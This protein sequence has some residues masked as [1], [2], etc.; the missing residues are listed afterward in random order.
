MAA[1]QSETRSVA[2]DASNPQTHS[3]YATLHAVDRALRPIYSK[4]GLAL[5]FDTAKADEE[6]HI[7]VLCT[8]ALGKHERPYHIDMPCDGKGAKGNDV[9]TK[10][11]A[12]G[13]AITYG[14]RYLLLMIFN[15]AIGDDDGNAAGDEG[16]GDGTITDKQVDELNKLLTDTKSNLVLFLKTIKLESLT[17]IGADKFE[18]VKKLINDTA[19]KRA[20][21]EGAQS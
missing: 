18:A 3:K 2:A 19:A 5:M 21:R 17:Q 13:S 16:H 20:A 14:R 11:H 15:V 9:M 8:V 12:V 6:N 4:H 7:R 1:A 10:T